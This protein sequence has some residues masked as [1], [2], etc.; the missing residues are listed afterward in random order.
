[1]PTC[2]ATGPIADSRGLAPRDPFYLLETTLGGVYDGE[3]VMES[4]M[5]SPGAAVAVAPPEVLVGEA[6]NENE[7]RPDRSSLAAVPGVS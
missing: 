4:L 1:M 7:L 2:G 6:F 5:A 3:G